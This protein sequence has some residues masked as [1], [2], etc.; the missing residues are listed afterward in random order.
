M[1]KDIYVI[2]N[3]INSKL[4]VGQAI[5]TKERFQSHCKPSAA[6]RENEVIA[7]AIQKYGKELFWYEIL[8]HQVEDYNEKEIYWIKKLGSL[9]PYG[10]NILPGGESPP[11]YRGADNPTAILSNQKVEELTWDLK[12]TSITMTELAKK[13]GF[14]SITSVSEFNKGITYVRE[15]DYPI[16]KEIMIGQ[17]KLTNEQ[18]TDI[19]SI[20]K[21]TYRSYEDIAKQYQVEYRAIARINKGIFHKRENEIYPIR[22][23]KLG[24]K[25]PKFTYEQVTDIISYLVNTKKSLREIASIFNAE[26]RDILNIKNGTT[27]LYRRRDLT[28]PLRPNN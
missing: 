3:D 16:R 13:Y 8:E 24:S 17:G 6:Y 26:Y 12:N 28:Y 11:I 20:L 9:I 10:Y 5:N 1:K 23:G 4:Y 2:K 7:K 21:N 27:I 19:I 18:V 15:I 14:S 25:P 22:E